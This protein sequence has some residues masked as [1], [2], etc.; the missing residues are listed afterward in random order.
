MI[1][2]VADNDVA[3]RERIEAALARIGNAQQQYNA[4][5]TIHAKRA[6]ARANDLD[7]LPV[8]ERGPMH[9][10]PVVVKDLFDIAAQPTTGC[11]GA[12][13]HHLASADATVV[14]KLEAAGAVVVAKTNQHELGAGATGLVSGHGPV[15]NPIDSSRIIG[16]SSSGSAAAVAADAVPLAIGSD[17]GGSIRIPA[18]FSG[19][20]GLRPTPGRIS[21]VGAQVMSPGYDTAGPLARTAADC[22]A[23]FAVL[24]SGSQ[25]MRHLD[26]LRGIDIGLPR[27]YFEFV[28]RETREA[29][30]A[31]AA[32]FESLGAAVEWTAA[33]DVDA[34]FAGFRHV[35]ADLAHHHR[36]V[37]DDPRVSDDVAALIEVGRRLTGLEYAASRAAA[38]HVQEQFSCALERFDLLLAPTTPY[39]APRIDE[40]DVEVIG[41]FVDVHRGG[42]SRLTVPVNEAGVPAV[43]FPVGTNALGLP[44]SAQL[45]GRPYTDET[46][47]AIVATYQ[48]T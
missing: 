19:I 39:P 4:F 32:Q 47:L 12:Y 38:A 17:T 27:A 8:S 22:A 48:A 43:A 45:I 10:T 15:I 16:G 28:D 2:T 41:G 11:C 5:T 29:V 31:A 18:S 23:A 26:D 37:W 36:R 14:A 20:T 1:H 24:A 6:L 33:P 13:A 9:G 40:D 46:L 35:W 21:L 42:P 3:C 7:S 44:L 30:E 25:P 34:D